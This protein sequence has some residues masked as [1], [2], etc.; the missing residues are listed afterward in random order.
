MDREELVAKVTSEVMA[1]LGLAG[2]GS[3]PSVGTLCDPCTACGLCVEKRAEDVESIIASG[4]SRISA[5]SGLGTAGERVA[6]MIDHT[7]LK[8]NATRQEIEKLCEEARRYRFASVCINPCNVPLCAQMLRM[9]NVKV[10]TVV[11]FPLGAN[12][13]EVKAFETERAIIDGAQEIDMVINV[14]ALKSK[15]LDL[16]ERD[17]R[18]VVEACR[19]IVVSKVI[20]E[21]ALLTDEEKVEAC[22]LAKAAGADFVKTSTGFGP[23]GATAHDVALMRATVG[24]EMGVKAAGGIR[25][26]ATAREM[27]EAGASRIG[28]SASVKIVGG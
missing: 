27:I 6:S 21:A 15:D 9:T 23:G 26:A 17:I 5:A 11:G 28:A 7:L 4:A 13:S 18:A 25:D 2:A 3:T 10:C 20:I 19:S 12:R 24:S 16:V 22:R 1:R 8:P 14:G